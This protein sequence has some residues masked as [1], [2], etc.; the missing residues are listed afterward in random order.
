[1]ECFANLNVKLKL[2]ISKYFLCAY[3]YVV[4]V[5]VGGRPE[6]KLN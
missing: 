5:W 1:M 6:Q 4:C 2:S 3:V